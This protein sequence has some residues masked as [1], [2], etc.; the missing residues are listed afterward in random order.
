MMAG[1]TPVRTRPGAYEFMEFTITRHALKRF[2]ERF[3]D[4]NLEHALASA[5]PAGRKIIKKARR[6]CPYH[7]KIGEVSR[8]SEKYYLYNSELRALFAIAVPKTVLTV[9]PIQKKYP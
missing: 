2:K 6:Q 5:R 3:P 8:N 7:A 4:S 1:S 9:Y